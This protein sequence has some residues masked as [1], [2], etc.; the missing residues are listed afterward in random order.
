MIQYKHCGRNRSSI[1]IEEREANGCASLSIVGVN[2]RVDH[3][4]A[5]R[6]WRDA[7]ALATADQANVGPVQGV[8]LDER[9]GVFD[10]SDQMRMDFDA[11]CD[12]TSVGSVK[13]PRLNP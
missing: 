7:P 2:H 1:V 8:L 10:S 5:N 9:D 6:D 12:P 11:V 13:S 4:F 3:R